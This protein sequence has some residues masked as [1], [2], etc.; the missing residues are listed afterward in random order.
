MDDL[1]M[2]DIDPTDRLDIRNATRI[3]SKAQ[4]DFILDIYEEQLHAYDS[5]RKAIAETY[6]CNNDIAN[7]IPP[8]RLFRDVKGVRTIPSSYFTK[9]ESKDGSFHAYLPEDMRNALSKFSPE[10]VKFLL[11]EY[12]SRI[13]HIGIILD[14]AKLYQGDPT[15][16]LRNL[17]QELGAVCRATHAHGDSVQTA[18]DSLIHASLEEIAILLAGI[19]MDSVREIDWQRFVPRDFSL[20]MSVSH[21]DHIICTTS[22]RRSS[23][24]DHAENQL[25]R[26][27]KR[28]RLQP[29]FDSTELT[30]RCAL[31]PENNLSGRSENLV[32]DIHPVFAD[33]NFVDCPP[34]VYEV[35][36][37]A[38]RLASML[39]QHRATSCY[40]HT[41]AFGK[42][43]VCQRNALRGE[44]SIRIKDAVPWSPENAFAFDK[45]LNAIANHVRFQFNAAT[46]QSKVYGMCWVPCQHQRY[47]LPLDTVK[48]HFSEIHIAF[49]FYTTAMRISKLRHPDPD[50]L[51]R[52]NFLLAVALTHEVAHFLELGHKPDTTTGE[53]YLND[54]D[55]AEAG[56][57]MEKKIFGGM[58]SS[59]NDR[60]DCAYGLCVSDDNKS[61]GIEGNV[62]IFWSIPM[63]YTTMIQQQETWDDPRIL[64][65]AFLRIPKTAARS[66]GVSTLSM[67]VWEDEASC[68]TIDAGALTT[69]MPQKPC[70]FLR[71]TDGNIVR[72]SY[73]VQP[74]DG[75]ETVNP[76][77]EL[78]ADTRAGA[79]AFRAVIEKQAREVASVNIG[80]V[81]SG[82]VGKTAD[83]GYLNLLKV[84]NRGIT[85]VRRSNTKGWK[86]AVKISCSDE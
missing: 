32:S 17:I 7:L 8:R 61:S 72:C 29:G 13:D 45:Q 30:K 56:Q 55:F 35:L 78:E 69:S 41:M 44:H 22:M 65:P 43:E 67:Q 71:E 73:L 23:A 4:L 27:S 62:P 6:S 37:P 70:E 15:E 50:M 25:I 12:K 59:I 33:R 68:R 60:T 47:V 18:E 16:A 21:R 1:E 20:Y 85:S 49:D 77:E 48:V 14:R 53:A 66:S 3:V 64:D 82:R 51:L 28:K 58:I 10:D 2:L 9:L 79:V 54:N 86:V 74:Q 19:R 5:Q 75:I 31:Y 46:P 63:E 24:S 39:L 83:T 26:R 36:K 81:K 57:A 76:P 11:S 80:R 34:V 84:T 42:R 38:L 40:W 52:F